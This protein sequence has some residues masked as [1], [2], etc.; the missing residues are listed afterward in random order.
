IVKGTNGETQ[1]TRAGVFGTDS[2]NYIVNK[3]G[4]RLQGYPTDDKDQLQTGTVSD[5]KIKAKALPAKA[6]DSLDFVANLDADKPILDPTQFDRTKV[7]TYSSIYTTKVHDSLGREHTLT[8]YF[9]KTDDNEWEALY[10]LDELPAQVG[11]ATLVFNSEGVMTEPYDQASIEAD[12]APTHTPVT[13]SVPA[14]SM[15]GAQA[16]SIA[17]NYGGP[18]TGATTQYGTDFGVSTNLASGYASGEQ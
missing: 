16:L 18:T 10:Y 6:T 9:I 11:S 2:A 13:V 1:Y 8:Q 7:E 4:Q 12:V 17:I 5:L 3:A 14:A 15:G